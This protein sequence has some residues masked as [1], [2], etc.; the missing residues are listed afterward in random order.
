MARSEHCSKPYSFSFP[1]GRCLEKQCGG[2][3]L[4]SSECVYMSELMR[5]QHFEQVSGSTYQEKQS[6]QWVIRSSKSIVQGTEW[7]LILRKMLN[8]LKWR[9]CANFSF[10][11]KCHQGSVQFSRSV[12]S[13]SLRPHESQHARPTCPSPFTQTHVHQVG[14]AI[15]PSHPL[16]SPSPPAPNPS[17]HQ[18]LFQWVNSLHQVAKVLEFQLQHQ[19]FQWTPRTDVL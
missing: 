7:E 14:D 8:V 3:S 5:C 9:K 17:Q 10:I 13:H 12:M 19:S 4:Q 11:A 6:I 15:P 2:E 18:G 1:L 16:S